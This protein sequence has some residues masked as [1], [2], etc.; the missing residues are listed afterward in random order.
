MSASGSGHRFF[1][2]MSASAEQTY[3]ALPELLAYYAKWQRE[4]LARCLIDQSKKSHKNKI[5]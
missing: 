1:A 3:G 2:Y 5:S 4:T